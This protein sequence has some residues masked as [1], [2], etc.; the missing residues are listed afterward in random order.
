M[1]KHC[2]L[3]VHRLDLVGIVL[4]N[5]LPLHL[6]RRCQLPALDRQ[7][8][9]KNRELLQLTHPGALGIDV[10]DGALDNNT[11]LVIVHPLSGFRV[12]GDERCEE[13]PLVTDHDNGCNQGIR[14]QCSLDERRGDVL[15]AG[16]DDDIF[17]AVG[18][19]QES[20]IIN[21]ANSI[22]SR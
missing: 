17:L 12:D 21:M 2:L 19:E 14:L 1:A 4:A 6:Q 8:I 11:D 22:A 7:R 18:D 13:R 9:T 20:I 3:R 10:I 5:D 15:T 16:R